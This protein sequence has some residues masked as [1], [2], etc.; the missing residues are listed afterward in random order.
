[1]APD[2]RPSI[3]LGGVQLPPQERTCNTRRKVR[4]ALRYAPSDESMV[5]ILLGYLYVKDKRFPLKFLPVKTRE[6][7]LEDKLMRIER[8][9]HPD[10]L[11]ALSR[12]SSE[13]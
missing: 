10:A 12:A 7:Y 4:V 2:Y 9:N 11:A 6:D 3:Y 1:M 5:A 8:V 13:E